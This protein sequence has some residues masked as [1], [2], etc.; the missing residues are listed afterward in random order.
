MNLEENLGVLLCRYL[1]VEISI[2]IYRC[3]LRFQK[4]EESEFI[5]LTFLPH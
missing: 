2:Q 4:V 5:S 1:L 3:F